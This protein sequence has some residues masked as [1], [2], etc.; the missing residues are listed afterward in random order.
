[1]STAIQFEDITKEYEGKTIIEN[2]NLS[3]GQG[4]FVTII[5]SS[6]CENGKW[7]DKARER[8]DHDSWGRYQDK[9]YDNV[10]KNDRICDSGQCL[11]STYERRREYC[12]CSES[13]K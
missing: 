12:V 7:A 2:L 5:G 1:M 6:G 8:N 4:E 13:V 10:S 3:I 11:I 9:R